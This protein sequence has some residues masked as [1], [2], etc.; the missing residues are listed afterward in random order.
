[1]ESYK[2]IIC[3]TR[4][5]LILVEAARRGLI[6]KVTRRLNERERQ[7]IAPGSVYIWNELDL[8]MRR[9]TDGRL[10][11]A[12][13]VSGPFLIYR[14]MEN[15]PTGG[16][17]APP[18]LQSGLRDNT[19][20]RYK[21]GGFVKQLFLLTTIPGDK[22]HLIAY[23]LLPS[24]KGVGGAADANRGLYP[25]SSDKQFA[26]LTLLPEVYPELLLVESTNSELDSALD[27]RPPRGR[28]PLDV[29]HH[30]SSVGGYTTHTSP[31]VVHQPYPP[32]AYPSYPPRQAYPPMP[33]RFPYQQPQQY[34]YP[35]NYYPYPQGSPQQVH[36]AQAQAAQAAQ[37]RAYAL[38]YYDKPAAPGA[39]IVLPPL[40]G[41]PQAR[42]DDRYKEDGKVLGLLNKGF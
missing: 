3:S 7:A 16:L 40:T 4:D 35:P 10:W 26:G 41:N 25:P 32:Q 12:L 9:W 15:D 38:R 20:Y 42:N 39:R 22:F 17:P 21:T 36:A 27:F 5:A 13:R 1:M 30:R 34:G 2:G 18:M 23:T 37:A 31:G 33:S 29:R 19:N 14:E 6:P 24:T 8:G 11:L 28:S